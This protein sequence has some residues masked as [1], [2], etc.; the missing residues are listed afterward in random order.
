MGWL[1]DVFLDYVRLH[2][3]PATHDWYEDY[4]RPFLEHVGPKLRV[5]NLTPAMVTVWIGKRYAG[6]SA[7]CHNAAARSVVRMCNWAVAEKIISHSPLVGFVKPAASRREVVCSPSQYDTILSHATGRLRDAVEFLWQT[8]CRPFELR[9]LEA[10]YVDDRKVVF[11][12]N[13]SKGGK[14]RR[15]IYLDDVAAAIV[16]RLSAE[17]PD[18]PI[19]RNSRGKP[20][21][22]DALTNAFGRL[23][24][25]AKIP[26]IT[27]YALRHA[28]ATEAL[29]RGTDTTTVGVL[30][31][32]ANPNMV[33]KV[34]QHLAEDDDYMLRVVANL[35]VAP[36]M[37]L[38]WRRVRVRTKNSAALLAYD[39]CHAPMPGIGETPIW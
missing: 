10:K 35:H 12:V 26:S 25:K 23:R 32:H 16:A 15:V 13:K 34:Y 20:W 27:P 28:F 22:K 21:H 2:R 11:P 14:R 8:G 37:P 36:T 30:L 5:G 19:F 3:S 18:G 33:A 7:S 9:H 17:F 38:D 39:P 29:K 6:R 24:D 31:G 4:L 1:I